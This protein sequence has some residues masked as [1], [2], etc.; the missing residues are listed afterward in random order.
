MTGGEVV[1]RTR[2]TALHGLDAFAYHG[3][4]RV[5]RRA[6][7]PRSQ[8]LDLDRA[9][10]APLGF[11]THERA[12]LVQARDPEAMVLLVAKADEILGGSY[13]YFG[14]P[15]ARV[16][17][18]VDFDFDPMSRKSWP[19]RHG[20]RIDYRLAEFGDP[21][22]I[23][24]LNR[25]QELPLLAAASLLTDDGRYAGR[26][27]ELARRWIS[28]SEPGRGI[29]WSNGFEA[30]LRAISLAVFLDALRGSALLDR[31]AAEQIAVSLWQ[32]A[33]W[34]D[35]DPSTHSSANNH[36]IGELVGLVTIGFLVPELR[37][38]EGLLARSLAGLGREAERQIAP[39][40][41]SVEQAFRYHLFVL[42]QLL[43]VVALLDAGGRTCPESIL[44]ALARSGGAL[45][46]QLGE[47]DPEPTYGDA[48][49]GIVLRLGGDGLRTAR[50]VAAGI[51]ARLGDP[52]ARVA[53][54][55]L[56]A[57]ACWLFGDD[58]VARFAAAE[59][60][61]SPRSTLLPD[62]GI[63]VLRAGRR[64]VLF[65]AGPLGYLAT[66]AHG[67]ADALQVT[68]SDAG[69][70][71]VV[72]PGV[73]SYFGKPEVRAAL[74][75]T[76]AHATVCVDGADQSEAGGPFLWTRHASAHLLSVDTERGLAIG[77]HDGYRLLHDP[78]SHRRLVHID[79]EEPIIVVD[80][81]ESADAHEVVQSWPLHPDL[82]AV[83]EGDVVR[84]TRDGRPR[85][86]IAVQGTARG[87]LGL[88]RGERE[89]FRGWYSRRLE[90]V[91]PAWLASWS[92][93]VAGSIDIVALVWPLSVD[94]WP[95]PSLE[96]LPRTNGLEIRYTKSGTTRTFL[97]GSDLAAGEITV[98][99]D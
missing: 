20:K 74:R 5:W 28:V 94:E 45:A 36:L 11:V 13:Q 66:A 53:A 62:A 99:D 95:E 76:V 44:D 16:A 56:D 97:I 48:D 32:H 7:M 40:G 8:D 64:R 17:E 68:V 71:L 84:A 86:L 69:E 60:A 23:W 6:W 43:A 38:A 58:G 75:G 15:G 24:E 96:I 18:P 31:S 91:E 83:G 35:R 26:G 87:R 3:A 51:A 29:A 93:T 92:A 85:L 42:D 82:D 21:K 46:A 30:G 41:T 19:R 98:L 9:P 50:G 89:P 57:T 70:D 12:R 67:H 59:P 39:D 78:V 73:G 47:S 34:I 63:V 79:E 80:R 72:D 81:L 88:L 49:D 33:R 90:H 54:R 65:D 10:A 55:T 4:K 27:L 61:P 1:A 52:D 22:W 14:Y 25:L 2:R 37:G 77:D